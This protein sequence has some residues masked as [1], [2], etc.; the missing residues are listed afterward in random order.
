MKT[1]KQ[2]RESVQ[3]PYTATNGRKERIL[4]NFDRVSVGSTKN[5]VVASLG[6]PD[7]EEEMYPMEPKRPCRGY[8]FTYYVEKPEDLTNEDRDKRVQ[9]FFSPIGKATSVVTN[10][11]GLS[12]KGY[13]K[14]N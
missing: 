9:V 3:L 7:Y 5:D 8:A 14:T 6:E 10:V 2:W 11:S 13:T 1:Y 12:E 4:R